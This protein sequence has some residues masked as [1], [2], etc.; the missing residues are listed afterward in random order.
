MTNHKQKAAVESPALSGTTEE[1][2]WLEQNWKE[3]QMMGM[4]LAS[5]ESVIYHVWNEVDPTPSL[6]FE[7]SPISFSAKATFIVNMVDP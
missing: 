2:A 4:T 5:N 6:D 7:M 3:G 1:R